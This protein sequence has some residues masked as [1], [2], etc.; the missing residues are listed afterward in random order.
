[1]QISFQNKIAVITGAAKGIGRA[2][3]EKCAALGC[4][5]VIADI[6][7]TELMKIEKYL[8]SKN[9]DV[10]AMTTD[11]AKEKS[12]QQLAAATFAKFGTPQLLFNNAG[13]SG[14][15]GPIWKLP[16]SKI[17]RIMDLN[18]MSVVY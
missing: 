7:Q 5:I 10:L 11:V 1:M 3:A 4:K 16:P 12:L 9:I 2:L 6:D 18:F 15:V 17:Q 14:Y 13:V 8:L